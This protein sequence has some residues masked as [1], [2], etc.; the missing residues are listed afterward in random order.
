MMD[1]CLLDAQG[2]VEETNMLIREQQKRMAYSFP[3][4]YAPEGRLRETSKSHYMAVMRMFYQFNRSTEDLTLELRRDTEDG[5][6]VRYATVGTV[7]S[8]DFFWSPTETIRLHIIA[9]N[10]ASDKVLEHYHVYDMGPSG[11]AYSVPKQAWENWMILGRENVGGVGIDKR[12]VYLAI[13]DRAQIG[14]MSV[15]EFSRLS[16]EQVER[17]QDGLKPGMFLVRPS[18]EDAGLDECKRRRSSK[19]TEVKTPE[20]RN[21][22]SSDEGEDDSAKPSTSREIPKLGG[23]SILARTPMKRKASYNK[24]SGASKTKAAGSSKKN[25]WWKNYVPP[26]NR[27][28]DVGPNG[29]MIPLNTDGTPMSKAQVMGI[30]DLFQD[31]IQRRNVNQPAEEGKPP[32]GAT[33]GEKTPPPDDSILEESSNSNTDSFQEETSVEESCFEISGVSNMPDTSIRSVSPGESSEEGGPLP[34]NDSVEVFLAEKIDGKDIINVSTGSS[35]LD[36]S[37]GQASEAGAM[38]L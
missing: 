35:S 27:F 19:S 24:G 5:L 33:E 26:P 34:I 12:L 7:Y 37:R 1:D 36:S 21:K 18:L 8:A 3:V 30:N 17:L 20:K 14:N 29:Q 16:C 22:S 15:H 23:R 11:N 25:C 4:A 9:A 2:T 6:T 31:F 32:K 38:G 13:G 28:M 10:K